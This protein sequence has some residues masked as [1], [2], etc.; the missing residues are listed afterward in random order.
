MGA[1]RHAQIVGQLGGYAHLAT[2]LGLER[3]SVRSWLKKQRGIPPRYWHRL[4][5]LNPEI[6]P[7]LLART[8]PSRGK[9]R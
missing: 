4:A 1:T 5:R 6:T 8:H 7:E 2:V 3:E 9:R